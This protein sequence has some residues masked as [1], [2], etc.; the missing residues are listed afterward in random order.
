[1][2][3][4]KEVLLKSN[5]VYRAPRESPAQLTG[6]DSEGKRGGER[7]AREWR[8]MV[9]G[10]GEGGGSGSGSDITPPTPTMPRRNGMWAA[11]EDDEAELLD[12]TKRDKLAVPPFPVPTAAELA[13]ALRSWF[14]LSP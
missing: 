8:G 9:W 3:I 6:G 4:E 1:M 5:L 2:G 10:W 7:S 12:H 14:S 11:P 13:D